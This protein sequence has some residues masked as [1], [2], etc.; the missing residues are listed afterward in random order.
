MTTKPTLTTTVTAASNA[1]SYGIT[2]AGAVD[3]NYSITY[4]SGTLSVTQAA[5]T[6]TANNQSK[7]YGAALP[8]F[9]AS[10]SGFVNGDT[11]A[12]LTTKPVLTTTATAASNVGS[13]AVTAAGAVDANYS[14][15]YVSGTL[16]V[17]QAALTITANN[18][19]MVYG[20]ALPALT[21]NYSGFV[22]GDTSASLTTGPTLTTT[23]TAASHVGS[24]GITAAGAVDAN[25][26][27]TYVGGTLS[28][29]QAA[30]TI[31]A[32]NQSMVY[33]SALP[34]LTASYSGF[35]NGDSSASLTTGPTLITTATAASHVGSYGIAAA[36]AIDADYSISYVGGTLNVTQ[37]ALTI[38]VNNQSS[39][40]GSALP[41]LTAS[42]I[43]FVNGDTSASLTAG[44][45]LTTTATA[46]SHFG[47]YG[48]T[49][50]GAVDADYA[51]SYVS[52]T[53]SIKAALTITSNDLSKIYGSAVPATT[54]SYRGL[55]NG[56][57]NASLA[58]SPSPLS[59]SIPATLL[60]APTPALTRATMSLSAP[61][62]PGL[63]T[64][65]EQTMHWSQTVR[66]E[67]VEVKQAELQAMSFETA[68]SPIAGTSE[69]LSFYLAREHRHSTIVTS[70]F[71][72]H[73][74]VSVEGDIQWHDVLAPRD[75]SGLAQS[76]GTRSI[77]TA[78]GLTAAASLGYLVWTFGGGA[79][80]AG[81][82]PP[83]PLW[84]SFNP[85]PVLSFA[86][87]ESQ[88]RR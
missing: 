57:T 2:A 60:E 86:S 18:Q 1:G 7:V 20:A 14:I 29:T 75:D 19:S 87:I 38:T 65:P 25:Y 78:T 5:L 50:A 13:Y 88:R 26:R 69:L 55:V 58:T 6:I 37:A 40:Y 82:M 22:N 61:Q 83:M 74:T 4:V 84:S 11:S 17:T 70:T 72:R 85:A 28:V 3:A 73:H 34:T 35:V 33:G 51:I 46:S 71:T 44:P 56:S 67:T 79:L 48:I 9:T 45:M 36:G 77:V 23:A 64:P 32:N 21:A 76:W 24:Y 80:L 15:T 12:S 27:I 30:L 41:A 43:G 68:T 16:S 8:T 53:L 63:M 10:Y 52:G 47:S 31:T 39:V 59:P 54:A 62:S 42:Y 66:A 49:A 81:A